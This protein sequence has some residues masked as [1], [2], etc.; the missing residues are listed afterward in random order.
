PFGRS[1]LLPPPRKWCGT[2][3]CFSRR[4]S[5]GRVSCLRTIRRSDVPPIP[6]EVFSASETPA[7]CSTPRA[8][9]SP[10]N[11][12][13]LMR[14]MQRNPRTQENGQL[15]RRTAHI[16]RPN[17]KDG[18]AGPHG[19]EQFFDALLHGTPEYDILVSSGANGIRQP[20]SGN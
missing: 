3:A 16:A 12:E 7:L 1:T 2:P 15:A 9:I 5:S 4:T 8:V 17:G 6:R 18:V 19:P 20:L 11:L 10:I 14:M 13:S